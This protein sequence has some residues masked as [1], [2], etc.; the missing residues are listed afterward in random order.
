ML[1]SFQSHRLTKG[2]SLRHSEDIFLCTA[3]AYPLKN[4][5]KLQDN[6]QKLAIKAGLMEFIR[7]QFEDDE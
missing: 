2:W 5:L 4:N 6:F 7:R 3:I 1:V